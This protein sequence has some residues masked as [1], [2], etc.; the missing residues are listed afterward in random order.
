MN[1][2]IKNEKVSDYMSSIS[3]ILPKGLKLNLGCGPIQPDGWIN[4]DGSNRAFFAS[5]LNWLDNILVKLRIISE[6]EFNLKTKYHNLIRGL[7]YPDN[8][9]A[10]IYA[11]EL[12]EHFEYFDALKLTKE[13]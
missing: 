2:C 8:S 1:N 4:I 13:C 10:C 5:K 11:G 7:P 3:Y 9:I 12:W 6:T